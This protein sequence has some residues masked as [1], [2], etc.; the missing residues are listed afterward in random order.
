MPGITLPI[1]AF[2]TPANGTIGIDAD[3]SL[4]FQK[5]GVKQTV[6][7]GGAVSY[8]M[9]SQLV[10]TPA[11]ITTPTRLDATYFGK[12]VEV[13]PNSTQFTL[14]L[15]PRAANVGKCIGIRVARTNPL[16]FGPYSVYVRP[17]THLFLANTTPANAAVRLSDGR[18][19][20]AAATIEG[21]AVSNIALL[22]AD[23]TVD[24]AFQTAIGTGPNAVPT[25]LAV[26]AS[27]NIYVANSFTSWN[28]TARPGIVK[29]SSS[30]V[31]DTTFSSN[32]TVVPN[33]TITYIG[34]RSSDGLTIIV[35]QF[36]TFNGTAR[37]RIVALNSDGTLNATFQTNT[38][39]GFGTAQPMAVDFDS[40][41]NVY[42]GG[43]F[44]TFNGA[45]RNRLIKLSSVGVEDATYYTNLG[46]GGIAGG[47]GFVYA[48][49]VQPSDDKLLVGG[50]FATVGVTTARS[51]AR[52]NTTGTPDTT[53]ITN[54]GSGTVTATETVRAI[55]IT[56]TNAIIVMGTFSARS[57]HTVNPVWP[58][59]GANIAKLS[60]TGTKDDS[61]T[62]SITGISPNS[63]GALWAEADDV[64]L[65]HTGSGNVNIG[66]YQY[67]NTGLSRI[68]TNGFSE[69][70]GI[71]LWN[72]DSIVLRAGATRWEIV[73]LYLDT[74]WYDVGGITMGATVTA[75]TIGTTTLNT[76]RMRRAGLHE[77][78]LQYMLNQ[79]AA[80]TVGGNEYHIA[81]PVALNSLLVTTDTG[82]IPNPPPYYG[83]AASAVSGAI[84][85][86]AANAATITAVIPYN[87]QNMRV[88]CNA[89]GGTASAYWGSSL[90]PLS[91]A[92]VTL[93]L[94]FTIQALNV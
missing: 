71:A 3:G 53:F 20:V 91:A 70:L 24:A 62:N 60:S 68:P 35:G 80:G 43:S 13:N 29:I 66:N 85:S 11:A 81:M 58:N 8:D 79:T 44:T 2:G 34:V 76:V 36:T 1:E 22:N 23:G 75:P 6:S 31:L 48:L 40:S 92:A 86:G 89:L 57:F 93:H 63:G 37:N 55:A 77:V 18:L 50:T 10:N 17:D 45:T 56:S 9:L 21:V 52:L 88:V 83:A 59:S 47:S 39:T 72:N 54:M 69:F 5:A 64:L 67:G 30:G 14:R 82:T 94:T 90:Y 65:M 46:T 12:W 27:D 61:Y 51:F 19:V 15:P 16:T 74:S 32:V 84:D 33:A 28:G 25:V 87:V 26:D 73:S 7:T 78:E 38:G 41:G 4:V 49:K 42:I